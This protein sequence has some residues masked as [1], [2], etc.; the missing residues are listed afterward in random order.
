MLWQ[1]IAKIPVPQTKQRKFIKEVVLSCWRKG[2]NTNLIHPNRIGSNPHWAMK[3]ISYEGQIAE[4]C[5]DLLGG[6]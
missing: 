4:N 6:K 1:T 3:Q 2:E 5:H